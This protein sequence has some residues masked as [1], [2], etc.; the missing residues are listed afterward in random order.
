MTP[1][2]RDLHCLKVPERIKSRLC[3]L[4]QCCLQGTGPPYLAET[5]QLT[6][7]MSIR[8]HLLSAATPTLVVDPVD[9]PLNTRRPSV[10]CGGCTC[11]ELSSVFAKRSCSASDFVQ[12]PKQKCLILL[13]IVF[14]YFLLLAFQRRYFMTLVIVRSALVTDLLSYVS[15]N[16]FFNNNNNNRLINHI[17][18]DSSLENRNHSLIRGCLTTISCQLLRW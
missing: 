16:M 18:S 7:D 9:P 12:A 17:E 4:T 5:L 11:L 15:L 14:S 2:L 13:I 10:S 6:S 1:L 3:V 8:R